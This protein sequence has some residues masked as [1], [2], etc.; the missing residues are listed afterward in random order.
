MNPAT[1]KTTESRKAM[2]ALRMS[3]LPAQLKPRLRRERHARPQAV[4]AR[5][6]HRW[7][8]QFEGGVSGRLA[9]FVW[10]LS[11]SCPSAP[12]LNTPKQDV[13]ARRSQTAAGSSPAYRDRR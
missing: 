10:A 6:R 11:M 1:A 12:E 13:L 4:L 5:R 3:D 7:G 2:S 8:R 9:R